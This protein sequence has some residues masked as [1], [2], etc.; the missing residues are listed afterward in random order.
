MYGRGGNRCAALR[1]TL[2]AFLPASVQFVSRTLA[3]FPT[4]MAKVVGIISGVVRETKCFAQGFTL[5][6]RGATSCLFLWLRES[7]LVSLERI[8]IVFRNFCLVLRI[9]TSQRIEV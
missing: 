1:W 9:A 5:L 4:D 8:S 2:V 6:L 3:L 7:P